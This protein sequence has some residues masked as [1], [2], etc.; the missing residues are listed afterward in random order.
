MTDEACGGLFLFSDTRHAL[1][2]SYFPLSVY[3]SKGWRR[4]VHRWSTAGQPSSRSSSVVERRARPH[5]RVGRTEARPVARDGGLVL[6]RDAPRTGGDV[7]VFHRRRGHGDAPDRPARGVRDV[8][9][10]GA[11][12]GRA[13]RGGGGGGVATGGARGV[14]GA[15]RSDRRRESFECTN[16]QTNEGKRRRRSVS[17]AA[18]RVLI[19]SDGKNE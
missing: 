7:V 15:E 19:N 8:V 18:P 12:D 10:G 4:G 1:W 11:D 5:T 16:R 13:E 9:G 3:L 14:S 6:P 2:W 17:L